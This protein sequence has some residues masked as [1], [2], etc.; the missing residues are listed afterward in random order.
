[1]DLGL[2][3]TFVF[4]DEDWLRKVLINGLIGLIPIVGQIYLLGWGL[5]VARRVAMDQYTA[6]PDMDF[7][8]Y[9]RRGFQALV[10]GL[11]YGLPIWL[12]VI[13]IVVLPMLGV[14]MGMDD[15]TLATLTMVFSVCCGGLIFVYSIL[16]GLLMPVAY[17]HIA[18]EDSLRAAFQFSEIFRLLK[19]ALGPWLL[20]FVGTMIA[21]FAASLIGSV[22]CGI[23]VIFTM[24]VYFPVMGH[25]YGQAYRQ[26]RMAPILN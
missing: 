12:F 18:V 26:A 16:L 14:S 15:E 1:M 3:L 5:E 7:G 8:A 20:A 6:L 21:G 2:A 23:G 10:V 13:P 11:V 4:Q 9:L 24:A 19:V 22:L 17:A 25:L